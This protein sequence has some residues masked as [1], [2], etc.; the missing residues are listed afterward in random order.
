MAA[1]PRHTFRRTLKPRMSGRTLAYKSNLTESGFPV[2]VNL[3]FAPISDGRYLRIATS[4]EQVTRTSG[5]LGICDFDGTP[6][7]RPINVPGPAE[8]TRQCSHEL[9]I[10]DP[11]PAVTPWVSGSRGLRLVAPVA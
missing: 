5:A 9:E 8:S 10:L 2:V 6:T 3:G 4:R 11:A 1:G 7:T